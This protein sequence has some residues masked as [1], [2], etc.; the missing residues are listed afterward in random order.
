MTTRSFTAVLSRDGD[1]FVALCPE[2]DIA[3]QGP[4]VEMAT[5]NL[6]EAV[7]LFLECADPRE[8]VERLHGSVYVTHFEAACG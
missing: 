8:V 5:A 6:K 7:E 1:G 2:L 3:S 4:T